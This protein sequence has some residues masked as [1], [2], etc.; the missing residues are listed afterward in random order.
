MENNLYIN[1]FVI[2]TENCDNFSINPKYIGQLYI[3][4]TEKRI[5]KIGT[6]YFVKNDWCKDFCIELL[7]KADYALDKNKNAITHPQ[8]LFER[9]KEYN[10]IV[11]ISFDLEEKHGEVTKV[12]S[13]EHFYMEYDGDEINKL[14]DTYI[15]DNGN[16]YITVRSSKVLADKEKEDMESL[17]KTAI[18]N[19]I[20]GK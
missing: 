10:D 20:N 4:D 16:M 8:T 14:Q 9:L 1:N 7:Q 13:H 15:D 17:V 12:I 11:D 19:L 5:K 6:D 18:K 2:H 3:G